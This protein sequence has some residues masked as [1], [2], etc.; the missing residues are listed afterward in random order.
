M[1]KLM[2]LLLLLVGFSAASQHI[3]YI[4][5]DT[6]QY[7][8]YIFDAKDAMKYE[9]TFEAPP[10]YHTQFIVTKNDT[11]YYHFQKAGF[12]NIY[13]RYKNKDGKWSDDQYL[14]FDV[15]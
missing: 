3:Q 5:T 14:N 6:L 1:K 9:W 4:R 10:D 2:I 11:T 12:V 7:K 8:F 15:K 13:A